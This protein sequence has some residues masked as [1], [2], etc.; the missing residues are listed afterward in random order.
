MSHYVENEHAHGALCCKQTCTHQM[1]GETKIS[2]TIRTIVIAKAKREPTI[3]GHF[4]LRWAYG[5]C[6]KRESLGWNI[7]RKRNMQGHQRKQKL[8]K[9]KYT[10]QIR[11]TYNKRKL[12]SSNTKQRTIMC[13]PFR[14]EKRVL[15]ARA[16]NFMKIYLSYLRYDSLS[17]ILTYIFHCAEPKLRIKILTTLRFEPHTHTSASKR[18]ESIEFSRFHFT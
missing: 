16:M 10:D 18:W 8:W 4:G 15:L 2:D 5:G 3:Y 7:W 9:A 12:V 11:R 13:V 6:R 17:C 14:R 1:N